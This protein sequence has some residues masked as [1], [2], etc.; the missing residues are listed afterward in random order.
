MML[1]VICLAAVHLLVLITAWF[2]PTASTYAWASGT[3]AFLA[4]FW[5]LPEANW[6]DK[7]VPGIYLPSVGRQDFRSISTLPAV[8]SVAAVP[9]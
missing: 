6:S 3:S 1:A 9:R 8:A 4:P 5:G 2:W 7:A